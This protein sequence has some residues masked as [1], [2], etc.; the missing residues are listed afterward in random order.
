MVTG[1]VMGY[2]LIHGLIQRR[3]IE[4]PGRERGILERVID[5]QAGRRPRREPGGGCLTH[6]TDSQASQSPFRAAIAGADVDA[7]MGHPS[8]QSAVRSDSPRF[9]QPAS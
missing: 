1:V 9:W 6:A 2:S 4:P 3:G 5:F 8:S 7:L